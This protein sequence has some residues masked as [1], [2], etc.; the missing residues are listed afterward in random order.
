MILVDDFD[1]CIWPLLMNHTQK[2]F[3]KK[4]AVCLGRHFLLAMLAGQACQNTSALSEKSAAKKTSLAAHTHRSAGLVTV[5]QGPS[6]GTRYTIQIPQNQL[7][8]AQQSGWQKALQEMVARMSTY[9]ATSEVS[10]FGQAQAGEAFVFSE[11]TWGVLQQAQSIWQQSDGAF[12]P[13]VGPLLRLWGFGAGS[14]RSRSWP[15]A[16]DLTQAR[17]RVGFG[18]IE[19]SMANRSLSKPVAGMQLDLSAIAKGFGVDVVA[20]H[21]LKAGVENFM[22]EIGGEV[23]VAGLHPLGRTWRIAIEEPAQKPWL[24]PK[25]GGAVVHLA[26]GFSMA[27][28]GDYRNHRMVNGRTLGHVVDPRTGE[29]VAHH[30]AS[31]SVVHPSCALA[32]AWATALWVLGAE[33]GIALA[34]R[35]G[36]HAYMLVRRD[37]GL[38]PSQGKPSQDLWVVRATKGFDRFL[39]SQLPSQ[40]P[41]QATEDDR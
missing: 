4:R 11:Q 33:R 18:K 20:E 39:S 38:K 15:T 30:T 31:V 7:H 37:D 14:D 32:D 36:L 8:I 41:V 2:Q 6:M 25:G 17:Q 40:A 16:R 26:S 35:L 13:T 22:V 9:D 12:D 10:R 3:S 21:L 29:P 19:R 28:S 34:E 23:R 1:G 27:T 24:A 5:L